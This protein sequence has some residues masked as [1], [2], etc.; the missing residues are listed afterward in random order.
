MRQKKYKHSARQNVINIFLLTIIIVVF[1]V[2]DRIFQPVSVPEQ[3][4]IQKVRVLVVPGHE[5]D[6]GG[7]IFGTIKER[8]LVVELGQNLKRF[9]ETDGKYEVFVTR[10]SEEWN[11]TFADYF[12]NN[13]DEII[14]WQKDA[15]EQFSNLVS[16]GLKKQPVTAVI[17]NIPSF[18]VGMRIYGITKWSNEN[19]IDL[20][21][22]L[23]LNDYRGRSQKKVGKYSGFAIYVP[24]REYSNSAKTDPIAQA[25]FDRLSEHA[26]VSNFGP[27][28]GGIIHDPKLIAVGQNDTSKVANMLIEYGYIYEPQFV[29]PEIRSLSLEDLAH[30]T[31]LGLED[32]FEEGNGFGK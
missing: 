2:L 17:H 4:P 20:V 1:F 14:F 16:A 7:A 13:L 15:K 22:H 21:I 5:P 8:D 31:Y 27:E 6:Y 11:P 32:Y 30:Q 10:D 25:I 12:K 3:K 24:A 28:L 18:E 23:H 9:L 29:N 19:N 26:R